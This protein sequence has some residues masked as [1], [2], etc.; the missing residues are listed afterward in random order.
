FTKRKITMK[1]TPY[2]HFKGQ[3]REAFEFYAQIFN[4]TSNAMLPYEDSPEE[5]IAAQWKDQILHAHISLDDLE[6][7]GSD[8][9]GDCYAK[10]QGLYVFISLDELNEAE[11]IYTALSDG[12]S[13]QMPFEE[14]FWAEGYAMFIDR[15]GTPWM[16]S[17]GIKKC[18]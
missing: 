17:F 8:V 4:G 6:L 13:I 7:M 3:C 10:P 1:M 9:T 18:L 12:G 2:L 16:I 14:R 15:Y 11:R 5:K